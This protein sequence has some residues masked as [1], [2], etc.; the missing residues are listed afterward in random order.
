MKNAVLISIRPR[1][2][3]KI[4]GRIKTDELRKTFPHKIEG[5]YKCFMYVT[6][7]REPYLT[8]NVLTPSR[9]IY[10]GDGKIVAE[11][12][13]ETP[14]PFC[15]YFGR[16]PKEEFLDVVCGGI[17]ITNREIVKYLGISSDPAYSKRGYLWHINDLKVYDSPLTLADFGLKRAPQSWCYVEDITR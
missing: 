16:R 12:T 7:M 17:E 13:C 10:E 15:V 4:I 6:K 14:M 9:N 1:H 3:A 11:W 5:A 8:C 2:A